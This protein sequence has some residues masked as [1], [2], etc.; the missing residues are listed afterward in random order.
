MYVR[1]CGAQQYRALMM[2]FNYLTGCISLILF[3]SASSCNLDTSQLIS[4]ML[5]R[6]SLYFSFQL[7]EFLFTCHFSIMLWSSSSYYK[8][9]AVM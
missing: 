3:Q 6:Q 1:M 8:E 4:P 2:F 7:M 9:I 5:F